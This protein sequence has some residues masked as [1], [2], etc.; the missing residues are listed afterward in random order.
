MSRE[1]VLTGEEAVTIHMFLSAVVENFDNARKDDQGRT[2][3]NEVV[4]E[5]EDA[6]AIKLK[7]ENVL[8]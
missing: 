3:G 1:L 7:I 8:F 6:R 4:K 2:M 5:I